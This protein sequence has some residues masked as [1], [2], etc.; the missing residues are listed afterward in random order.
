[1]KRVLFLGGNGHCAARLGPARAAGTP[2]ELVDVPYPGF[3]GRPR[4]SN[5][6]AF[7][8]AV[9]QFVAPHAREALIYA[10]G[11]GGLFAVALRA[12]GAIT[13][14]PILMQAPVLWGLER[15]WFPWF[16]RRGFWRLF[17]SILRSRRF[18]RRFAGTK[19][20]RVPTP[21]MLAAFFDGYQRCTAT[22]DFFHWL[23]PALLRK[24]EREL[25][26]IPGSLDR[27][28]FWWGG[29]DAVVSTDELRVTEQALCHKW[30]VHEFPH[31][32]HYPMIDEPDEWVRSLSDELAAA[33]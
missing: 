27:I 8:D 7:L 17:P 1:M 23:T 10:T 32:G 31:W 22:T 26:A 4:V 15:R 6:E 14:T 11:I 19:F 20:T 21:K 29:R 3:E 18:Q 28:R 25:A 9:Q 13:Q 16:M 2:F 30:P 12:R 33:R 5:F 24:L